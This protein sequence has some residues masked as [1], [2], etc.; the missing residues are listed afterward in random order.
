LPIE[1]PIFGAPGFEQSTGGGLLWSVGI[2]RIDQ[3]GQK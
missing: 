2:E 3:N 1:L